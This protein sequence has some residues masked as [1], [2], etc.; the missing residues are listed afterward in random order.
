M[1]E[2]LRPLL[3]QVAALGRKYGAK[4]LMLFGSRARADFKERSDIDIAVWG[5]P[6]P[7][8]SMFWAE[9]EELPTLLKFDV[10]HISP[11]TDR[12]FLENILKDGELLYEES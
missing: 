10:C 9:L 2:E 6:E 8:R 5:M 3:S 11:N 12:P 1:Q 4:R 7:Y